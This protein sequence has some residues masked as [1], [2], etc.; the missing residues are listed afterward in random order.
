V[1]M[2]SEIAASAIISEGIKKVTE[3]IQ[4]EKKNP[5]IVIVKSKP[6]KFLKARMKRISTV[7]TKSE[8]AQGIIEN[9]VDEDAVIKNISLIPNGTFKSSGQLLLKVNEVEIFEHDVAGDFTDVSILDI[10]LPSEGKIISRG[11]SIEI[12]A[13]GSGSITV[14]VQFD[15]KEVD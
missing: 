5:Q 14:Y 8:N 12:F 3:V 13:W 2:M 1:I 11:K 9:P 10:A 7:S 15:R 4:K 6:T